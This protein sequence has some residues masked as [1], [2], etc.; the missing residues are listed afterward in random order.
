MM[1]MSSGP[2]LRPLQESEDFELERLLE[3]EGRERRRRFRAEPMTGRTPSGVESATS[4][5]GEDS[6]RS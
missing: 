6:R 4:G 2:A 3:A 5:W 1:T